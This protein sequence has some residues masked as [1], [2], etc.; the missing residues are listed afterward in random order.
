MSDDDLTVEP[1]DSM[2]DEQSEPP[3]DREARFTA[4]LAEM[5]ERMDEAVRDGEN[6]FA[7]GM[8]VAFTPDTSITDEDGDT[9]EGIVMRVV[10]PTAHKDYD[11][12]ADVLNEVD[13]FDRNVEELEIDRLEPS[14]GQVPSGLEDLLG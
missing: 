13:A 3:F 14:G 2:D 9:A 7:A 8:I 1:T 11:N 12:I 6:V 4:E 10:N 5:K